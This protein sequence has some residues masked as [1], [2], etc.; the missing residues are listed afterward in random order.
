MHTTTAADRPRISIIVPCRNEERYIA[1]CLESILASDYPADRM[2][3]L[4]ADGRSDDGTRGVVAEVASRDER[5]RL[6]DNAQRI[7]PT[8]LNTAIRA[9]SGDII[10]RMD[11]HVVY[12]RTYLSRLISALEETGADNVGGVLATLPADDTPMAR[13]IALGLS[14][15]FGV[16]N[17]YF[18]VGATER[19]WVD[20]VAFGCY[21][22]DVF[23]RIGLFDEE[24]VRNQDDEFNARL[25]K[26]GGRILLEP[27][28]V[29]QYYGRR[30]LRHL[31]RMFFQYGLFKPLVARKVGRVMTVRQLVPALLVLGLAGTA[32]LT[33][34]VPIAGPAFA[35]LAGLYL[36]AV[37]VNA[38]GSVAPAGPKSAALMVLVFPTLHFSYGVGFLAGIARTLRGSGVRRDATALMLSR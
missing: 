21:R 6:L 7:T 36:A 4:V 38:I 31:A 34:W 22:R 20:T 35:V 8:A 37:A 18:R 10:V 23:E 19:R 26:N 15:R 25:I 17:S 9:A 11:A 28:V 12:P 3:V 13:A 33:P 24:L 1:G 30:S 5:V 27:A 16:G 14:H 2:E 29:A 32:L